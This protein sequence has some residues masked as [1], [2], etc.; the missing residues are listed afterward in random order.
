[1]TSLWQKVPNDPIWA[2]GEQERI[3]EVHERMGAR[4]SRRHFLPATGYSWAQAVAEILRKCGDDLSRENLLNQAT[5]L[6]G[7]H[8]SLF[9]DGV[10]LSTSPSDRT[11]WRQVRWHDSTEP[12]GY[13]S[14]A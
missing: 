9:I 3:F 14:G 13:H 6:K 5:N 10:N 7:F 1:L 4:G 2:E 11:P 8:P 12:V